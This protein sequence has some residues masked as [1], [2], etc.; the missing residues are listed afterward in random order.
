[1]GDPQTDRREEG[2]DVTVEDL[3]DSLDEIDGVVVDEDGNPRF[4]MEVV[5]NS[6]RQTKLQE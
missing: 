6:G 2:D 1:M 5:D 3:S 4:E